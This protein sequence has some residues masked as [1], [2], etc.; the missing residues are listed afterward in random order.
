MRAFQTSFIDPDLPYYR[1]LRKLDLID[2]VDDNVIMREIPK[3]L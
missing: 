2:M 1:Q 3:H